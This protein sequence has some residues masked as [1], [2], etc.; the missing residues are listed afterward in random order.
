MNDPGMFEVDGGLIY[1]FSAVS[2]V[3]VKRLSSKGK[4]KR[5][6]KRK[7]IEICVIYTILDLKI[8]PDTKKW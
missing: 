1:P 8:D 7:N 4:R 3:Q 2:L 6:G 5:K